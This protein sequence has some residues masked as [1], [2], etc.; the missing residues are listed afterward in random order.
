M[1][2][3]NI[4]LIG[5]RGSGKSTVAQSLA[6][7]LGWQCTFD[8]DGILVCQ[9]GMDIPAIVDCH[10]WNYF[11]DLESEVVRGM[12]SV[13]RGVIS[14]GGGVVLRPENM[15]VLKSNGVIVYLKASV[16]TLLARVGDDPNR[17][18]L[19][20]GKS[21]EEE[22]AS[23]LSERELLYQQYADIIV[24]TDYLDVE[25]SINVILTNFWRL[26]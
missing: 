24:E 11:R 15:E 22:V 26:E 8:L 14:T 4:V 6:I 17:P 23:V 20:E 7:R 13:Q 1:D 3:R 16:A 9:V 19:T 5:M 21:R 25:Q 10:G 12:K 2:M 18:A